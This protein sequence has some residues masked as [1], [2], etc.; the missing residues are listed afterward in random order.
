MANLSVVQPFYWDR[1]NSTTMGRY[2]HQHEYA[3]IEKFLRMQ[4]PPRSLLDIGCGSGRF[5][6]PLHRIGY[7]VVGLDYDAGVLAVF[8]QRSDKIPL[9]LS[10]MQRLPFG[11]RSFD[12]I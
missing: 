4:A 5:T 12:C 2:L 7:N 3:F 8:R 10:D 1:F 6:L 9:V 11:A